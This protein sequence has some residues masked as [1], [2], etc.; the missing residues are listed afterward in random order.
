MPIP[1]NENGDLVFPDT[2][3]FSHF[4]YKG[5]IRCPVCYRRGDCIPETARVKK[6]QF[7]RELHPDPEP[8][9]CCGGDGS[10]DDELSEEEKKALNEMEGEKDD[11]GTG[12]H[13]PVVDH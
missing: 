6:E 2:K 1:V 9:P 4:D 5:S 11:A 12:V 3:C 8:R 7:E 13:Q 10:I